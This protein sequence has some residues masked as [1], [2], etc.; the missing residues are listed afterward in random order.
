[1]IKR[2]LGANFRIQRDGVD[3]QRAGTGDKLAVERLKLSLIHI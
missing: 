2:R 3:P 1:M